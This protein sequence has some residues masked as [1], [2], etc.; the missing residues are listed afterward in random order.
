MKQVFSK[1]KY[2]IIAIIIVLI[3]FFYFGVFAPLEAELEKSLNQNFQNTV[4]ILEIN[5]E[6]E[7]KRYKEGAESLSSRTMIKNELA[8]YRDGEVSFQELQD[9][10]QA[11][12]SDGARILEN[13]IAAFRVSEEKLIASWGEK[14]IDTYEDLINYNNTTTEIK[15]FKNDC[16]VLINSTINKDDRKLGNDIVVFDL[17]SLMN[18][19]N[20]GNINCEIIYSEEKLNG[21]D[22][23]NFIVEYRR[24]LNTNY[25]LKSEIFKNDLYQRLN[26]LSSKIIGG[27]SLLLFIISIV[28]YKILTSTSREVINELENKVETITEI[29]ET[30][31]MLGIYNRSKFIEVL[32][33]E[34]YRSRRYD[35]DLSLI[36]FDLDHFKVINDKYGHHVGDEILIKI[37]EIIENEI[38]EIDLFARY[39]GDEFMILNPE[40]KLEDAVKLAERLKDKISST[41][42]TTVNNITLSFGVTK[43]NDND[44]IDSLLKR[45]DDALYQAKEKRNFIVSQDNFNC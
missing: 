15:V 16:L 17:Q 28:Y 39:G 34:I 37:T 19:I 14:E 27:F 4:S 6:N 1:M 21:I 22:K 30:D 11:K 38:R 45:V 5:V 8:E 10:T 32:E 7:L 18:E 26:S 25:W 44:D 23:N 35:H 13:I 2:L 40:T 36:M 3:I 33:S 42:F 24:L 12:Y 43:L 41:K 29:S 20:S 31:D 9:Y